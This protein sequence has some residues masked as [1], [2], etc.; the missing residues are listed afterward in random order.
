MN[1]SPHQD[2]SKR[3]FYYY[4]AAILIIL[5]INT[6]ITPMFFKPRV[7]EVT[8]TNFL[9][10][11]DEGKASKVEINQNRIALLCNKDGK[12]EIF[13]TGRVEDPELVNR[14]VKANVEF[15]QVI[16][17]EDSPLTKFFNNWIFPFL[18]F[19]VIGQL[20]MRF[21]G[22]KLGGGNMMSFGKSNAKVYIEAQTGKTFKDVAGQDEAKEALQEIV[23]FL[24]DPSRYQAIGAT[25]PKGVL[26]V[27]PP[28][29]GKTLLAKAVAGEAKVPFFSIS[30]SEFIEMFVGM[31]AARVRDLFKQAQEKA[32]CIV[33]IDEIDAIG[34]KRDNGAFGSNDEREQTLN[35][36][37]SEMDGF[38]GSKGVIILAAT[39]RPEV[40]DKALLRPGRFDRRVPVELPD[41]KGREAILKVHSHDVRI[42]PN[43]DYHTVA[44]ATSGASGA[45][46][47]NIV[48]EA[49]L[50][51]V[52]MGRTEVIQEDL[53]E[54]VEVVIAGAQRKGAVI[55]EKEKQL[56]AYHEIGHAL[57]AASQTASAPVRKITI[58]PRTSGALGYTMQVDT[59]EK[60]L[61]T[62]EELFNKIVT[63]TGG[64]SAEEV[65]FNKVTSG[66]SNDIEQ[67]TKLARAMITRFGMTSDFDMVALE[68][69][70]NAYLSGDT[71]LACAPETAAR[72]DEAVFSVVKEAHQKAR[73]ILETHRQKLDELAQYL[74]KK[75]TI[76]GDEFMA[77][78]K[79]TD[80]ASAAAEQVPNSPQE[81][82]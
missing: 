35:Q 66:A 82:A 57:V 52:R 18:L 9:K 53:E 70:N 47:A 14:L 73:T 72:I 51:A 67:A 24:H 81:G 38:D 30:G 17:R 74:L 56:I 65:V 15:S 5:V 37:L 80:P 49:A 63:L 32:P 44:L 69:V 11:V 21:L 54:S 45:E 79:G 19:M 41:L 77:I 46:L 71:S 12:D 36:L 75:E 1:D 26:L 33:F 60:V 34:K 29:T 59:E 22:P 6:I 20:I 55:S 10:M 61:M 50:R 58:I 25:M 78:L 76:T 28:G 2:H 68:T 64:R 43:V 39:N 42:S 23:S 13:V 31:G 3:V 48:N 62:K 27:G 16:P 4:L 40:L 7:Q 8:Y